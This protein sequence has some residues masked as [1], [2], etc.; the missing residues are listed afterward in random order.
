MNACTRSAGPASSEVAWWRVLLHRACTS[1]MMFQSRSS[2]V[3]H[4]AVAPWTSA[5]IGVSTATRSTSPPCRP[6]GPAPRAADTAQWP[7]ARRLMSRRSSR[8]RPRPSRCAGSR[9]TA[10]HAHSAGRKSRTPPGL[11]RSRRATLRRSADRAKP[12]YPLIVSATTIC[13][14][15]GRE[16]CDHKIQ[17]PRRHRRRQRRLLLRSGDDRKRQRRARGRSGDESE[18]ASSLAAGGSPR[19]SASGA[20]QSG[21]RPATLYLDHAPLRLVTFRRLIASCTSLTTTSTSST[22]ANW[23]CVS[24]VSDAHP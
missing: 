7:P 23:G 22:S 5:T 18:S 16:F 21:S 17:G 10:H 12:A 3:S 11:N 13:D 2:F 20:R 19:L 9:T 4:L 15:P 14:R 1:L 8:T 24:V 6:P